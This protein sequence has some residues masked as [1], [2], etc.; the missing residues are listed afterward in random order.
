MTALA[1]RVI[2]AGHPG[3]C[4]LCGDLIHRGRQIGRTPLGWSHVRCVI[5]AVQ[6]IAS[7]RRPGMVHVKSAADGDA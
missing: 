6:V 4:S 2:K 3:R 5:R 1:S 7:V